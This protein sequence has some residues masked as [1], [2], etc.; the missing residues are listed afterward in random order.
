V[1]DYDRAGV[2][3]DASADEILEETKGF[4]KEV[5]DWLKANHPNLLEGKIKAF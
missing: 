5:I 3:A 2:V 4:K 1:T